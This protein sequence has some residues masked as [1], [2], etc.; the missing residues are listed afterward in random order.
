MGKTK[1]V[2]DFPCEVCGI[3][4]MLQ[5]LSESYAIVRHYK[6]FMNGKPVCEYHWNSIEYV[7]G[8]LANIKYD[9]SN[10]KSSSGQCKAI[11]P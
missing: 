11:F 8:I 9:Q 10:H 6:F 4:G 7:N 2:K 5:I 1:C 3:P